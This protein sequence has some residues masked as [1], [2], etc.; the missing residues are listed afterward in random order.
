M[1][2]VLLVFTAA[3]TPLVRLPKFNP[4]IA[5]VTTLSP[6][7][8]DVVT[9]FPLILYELG[10]AFVMTYGESI[11]ICAE[12]TYFAVIS[13]KALEGERKSIKGSNFFI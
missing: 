5:F 10:A 12:V 2:T 1:V 6:V 4:P 7:P 3:G 9:L 13:A 8:V 11:D